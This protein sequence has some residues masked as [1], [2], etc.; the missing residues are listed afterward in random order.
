MNKYIELQ[1][2]TKIPAHSLDTYTTNI[3][4]NKYC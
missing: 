2:G 3:F 1:A 4:K